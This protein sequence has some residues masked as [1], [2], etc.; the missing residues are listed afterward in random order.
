MHS[1]PLLLSINPPKLPT[2]TG[3]CLS[4]LSTTLS[5]SKYQIASC[6]LPLNSQAMRA[7]EARGEGEKER[8]ERTDSN[9]RTSKLPGVVLSVLSWSQAMA[10]SLHFYL[11]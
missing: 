9:E 1:P 11:A 3:R 6:L 8:K 4:A 5:A 2:D 7:G 10:I